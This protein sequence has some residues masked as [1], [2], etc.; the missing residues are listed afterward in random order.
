MRSAEEASALTGPRLLL[1]CN[2]LLAFVAAVVVWSYDRAGEEQR[3]L[4]MVERTNSDLQSGL[5]LTVALLR[6]AMGFF[7]ASDEVNRR[8]FRAYVDTLDLRRKHPSLLGIGYAKR[9]GPNEVDAL[10]RKV[11][12]QGV[13][14]FTVW[15]RP[16]SEENTAIV[17]L[18]PPDRGNLRAMG[19][20]MMTE[21]VRRAA[22][23][24][25]REAGEAVASGPVTLVQE[26]GEPGVGF[27]IYTP[28]YRPGA[29]LETGEDRRAALLGYVYAP[30][31]V[32]EVFDGLPHVP[33]DLTIHVYDG[34]EVSPEN[35]IYETVGKGPT[36]P[37]HRRELDVAGRT[38]TLL[39]AAPVPPLLAR[40]GGAL[41]V[42]GAGVLVAGL[43]Y[44]VQSVQ[45]S[46]RSRAERDAT[47]LAESERRY[48]FLAQA[49]PH[50]VFAADGD[51]RLTYTN[52]RW[53]GAVLGE[54]VSRNLLLSLHGEDRHLGVAT[55]EAALAS[56]APWSASFRMWSPSLAEWR[57]TLGNAVPQLVGGRVVEWIGT[58]TDI[59]AQKEAEVLL[60]RQA[61]DLERRVAERTSELER[62]VRELENFA[63]VASHDLQEP[64]RKI[65]AFGD[66][67]SDALGPD[68]KPAAADALTRMRRSAQRLQQLI[69]DLLAFTRVSRT[70]VVATPVDLEALVR[71]A[72]HELVEDRPDGATIE[73]RSVPVVRGDPALL[74]Q[75][76]VNLLGN[77]L[78]FH[79]PGE[80]PRVRV[81]SEAA[82][83]EVADC[84]RHRWFRLLVE[85]DGIGFDP[86]YLHRIFQVFQRLHPR[87]RYE[88]TGIGLAICQR[89]AELHGG[90][91][92]ARSSPSH[93]SCFVVTLPR[94]VPGTNKEECARSRDVDR[95]SLPRTTP[96]T[97]S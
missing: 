38:W 35:L 66:R 5:D 97:V 43:V 25:A 33:R 72:A 75:L 29:R 64:L 63:A 85:D 76:V 92:T 68:I 89:V 62:S 52:E 80:A 13:E 60:Q 69:S 3:E 47:A 71:E 94:A 26:G 56:R 36:G 59:H 54:T 17:Y 96:T 24:R 82:G 31:R 4:R 74:R 30:V 39:Y 9:V 19:F 18:E 41:G 11:R 50:G 81:R 53:P 87:D 6:G 49:V 20:D 73:V 37:S 12:E 70:E 95:S 1:L 21:P 40:G 84:E 45:A 86:K 90:Q 57:W 65:V 46:A 83:D 32:R 16:T 51:G 67:L 34:T 91:I 28:H 23:E 77:A 2:L 14:G 15:P 55:W 8:E 61:N 88:G 48:R 78:K 27:L 79:R 58:L 10:E 44:R 7:Q 22:M 93:G 42:F